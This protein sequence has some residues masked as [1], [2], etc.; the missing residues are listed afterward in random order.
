MRLSGLIFDVDGTIADNLPQVF[1]AFRAGFAAAAAGHY[2]D[3]DIYALFGPSPEEIFQRAVPHRWQEAADR[4]YE[5]YQALAQ[6]QAIA[7]PGLDAA[8]SVAEA[9]G[10]RLGVVSGGS[11]RLVRLTLGV[12]GLHNRF[13]H[14]VANGVP[15]QP[16][17]YH[18]VRMAQVWGL[19]PGG[20]AYVGD[21]PRDVAHA[22]EAGLAPL[23]AAWARASQA[24]ALR[25][26][27]ALAVFESAPELTDWLRSLELLERPAVPG[28]RP[29]R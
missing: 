8:L 1:D 18:L 26:A 19:P 27:G 17:R 21:S 29:G 15:A 12:L 7:V 23:G 4:F 22:Q 10:L 9:L 13:A 5:R 28:E 11:E 24:E 16:K 6:P 20:V 3:D 14:V 2:R 25:R